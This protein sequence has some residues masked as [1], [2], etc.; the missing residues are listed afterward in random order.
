MSF[1]IITVTLLWIVPVVMAV[2]GFCIA[3]SVVWD[4]VIYSYD[5]KVGNPQRV[6]FS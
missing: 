3:I 2:V 1:V 4:L 6:F 5:K